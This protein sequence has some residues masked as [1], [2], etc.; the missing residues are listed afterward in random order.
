MTFLIPLG[1]IALSAAGA[2]LVAL[3]WRAER[4]PAPTRWSW[5]ALARDTLA[6]VLAAN[7][8]FLASELSLVV[9]KAGLPGVQ[10]TLFHN[11]HAWI[12][13]PPNLPLVQ[14]AGQLGLAAVAGFGWFLATRAP[15]SSFGSI[16]G[17]WMVFHGLVT[18]LMATTSGVV[19]PDGQAGQWLEAL[20]LAGSPAA[21]IGVL[22][23]L[24]VPLL[25]LHLGP[26]LAPVVGDDGS[27]AFT[28]GTRRILLPVVLAV[29]ILTLFRMPLLDAAVGGMLVAA[30]AGPWALL[31]AAG[32]PITTAGRHD[33]PPTLHQPQ[34]APEGEP[35]WRSGLVA[36]VASV[37][38]AF[39]LTSGLTVG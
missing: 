6:Y 28:I 2:I 8:A 30:I 38:V 25:A 3:A 33:D 5:S 19:D 34:R 9:A 13:D 39:Y 14:G 1:L 26:C 12:G 36:T 29:P 23:I 15:A 18:L 31:G 10:A 35:D 11:G 4:S 20:G 27:T 32:A 7:A 21:I 16:T 24:A 17:W 22:A 37:V